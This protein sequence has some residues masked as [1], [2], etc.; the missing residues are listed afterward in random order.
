[1]TYLK[2]L[3]ASDGRQ[4]MLTPWAAEHLLMLALQ[5]CL[6]G[7]MKGVSLHAERLKYRL[8][9]MVRKSN[10]KGQVTK[11][12]HASSMLTAH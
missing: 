9:H 6:H 3:I 8:S 12:S 10:S 5:L 4:W 7:A 1:M 2:G 11:D